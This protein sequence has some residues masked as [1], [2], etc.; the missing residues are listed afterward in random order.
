MKPIITRIRTGL[1]GLLLLALTSTKLLADSD[2]FCPSMKK[3][4][5]ISLDFQPAFTRIDHYD[6]EN[7]KLPVILSP[8]LTITSFYNAWPNPEFPESGPRVFFFERDLVARIPNL[9]SK[10][11]NAISSKDVEVLTDQHLPLGDGSTMFPANTIWPNETK[12]VGKEV[13]GFEALIVSQGFHI[14]LKAG[15]LTILNLSE[16]DLAGHYPEYV[17]HQSGTSM[18]NP[19]KFYH[20]VA[21]VDMNKDG[22]KDIVTVRS[23]FRVGAN[24]APPS[25]DLV[26][27][28]HPDNYDGSQTWV[29]HPIYQMPFPGTGPDIRLRAADFNGD[30]VDEL[31]ATHFFTNEGGVGGSLPPNGKFVIY[32]VPEGFDSWQGVGYGPGQVPPQREG[33]PQSGRELLDLQVQGFHWR[34]RGELAP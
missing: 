30:G 10:P 32:G 15:R 12:H 31:I 18:E 7:Q 19:D 28:E 14:A 33:P 29:E 16:P 2:S 9:G 20:A 6:L 8:S 22:R 5:V 4:G 23:G 34:P 3:D 11:V 26:W 17:V 25:G 27:F 24:F 21:L 13:F 1:F